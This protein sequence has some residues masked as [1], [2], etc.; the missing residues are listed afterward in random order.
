MS[1]SGPE[2]QER[3]RAFLESLG[4]RPR[5]LDLTAQALVHRSYAF[6]HNE[7]ADNERLEFLGDAVLGCLAA[8]FLFQRFPAQT[9]GELSKKKAFLVSRAELARRAE[10][11]QLADLVLLG[12]GEETS[13]GR[14]RSSIVGSALEALIGAL[15]FEL[16]F[17]E[18][19]RFVRGKVLVPSLHALEARA[20][21]D[22]KS[23][24]QE[25]IQKRAQP[26]PTYK[27]IHEEGPA[28]RKWFVME[29]YAG[30]RMLGRGEG[31]RIKTAENDAARQACQ[32]LCR[33]QEEDA[34]PEA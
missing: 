6:E 11:L 34:A 12:R 33:E 28:H 21:V 18:L 31:S 8:D 29:V 4:L 5:S 26:V 22:Y 30:G 3:I 19:R 27:K 2:R 15:F 16:P 13:G 32:I 25:L 20:H 24:L 17:E 23:R 1:P 14:E 7:I 9:E 10:E